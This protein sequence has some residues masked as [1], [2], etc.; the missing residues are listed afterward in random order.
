[1]QACV[2]AACSLAAAPCSAFGGGQFG[3]LR[4]AGGTVSF[5]GPGDAAPVTGGGQEQAV[6]RVQCL[7]RAAHCQGVVNRE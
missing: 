5:V 6:G 3:L 1:M 2:Q 7:V 4:M